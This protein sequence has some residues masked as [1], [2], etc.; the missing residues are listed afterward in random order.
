MLMFLVC[1]FVFSTLIVSFMHSTGMQI[2]PAA[3]FQD[4]S[5]MLPLLHMLF[6]H[7]PEVMNTPE[8]LHL[9]NRMRSAD[10]MRR[11]E[12]VQRRVRQ[13]LAI[14]NGSRM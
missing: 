7:M 4:P 2:I 11:D 3:M 14:G 1:V 5:R 8:W 10:A 12:Y 9:L 13:L 6:V